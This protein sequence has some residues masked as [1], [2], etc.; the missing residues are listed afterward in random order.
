[1]RTI[2]NPDLKAHLTLDGQ[3]RVRH[4]L[5]SQK[6]FLSEMGSARQAAADYLRKRAE[7]FQIP[8]SQLERL[9]LRTTFLDPRE[10]GVEY[11]EYDAKRFFAS[12]TFCYYQTV[13]NTPVWGAGTTVTVKENPFRITHAAH[14]GRDGLEVKLPDADTIKRVRAA[15]IQINTRSA[16]L[17][18]NLT[19]GEAVA[20][21]AAVPLKAV[22]EAR[23]DGPARRA[24]EN[25]PDWGREAMATRGLFWVYRYKADDRVPRG[26]V[27]VLAAPRRGPDGEAREV[28]RT[29]PLPPVP[30]GVRD[31]QH[32]LVAE[33]IFHLPAKRTVNWRALVDV[34]TGAILYLRALVSGVNGLVFTDDPQTSTGDLTL[35]PDDCDAVLNPHR[36]N[37][38]LSNLNAPVGGVQSLTGTHVTVVDEDIPAVAVPTAP[39]GTDFGYDSRTNQFAAVNAYY[40]ADNLFEAIEALGF[41][42]DVYF[43]GTAFPVHLDHRA[44]RFTLDGIE[45]DAF[46]DGD[47]QAD[48]IGLVGYCLSDLTDTAHPLGRAVDKWVHWHEIGGH[49]ILWDHVH[50]A[51]FGFAH[52][53][54]DALAAFQN[55]PVSLLRGRPER[56]RYA[57]FAGLDRWFD[58]AVADGWGWGGARDNGAFDY[59]AEQILATTLFRFYR[60]VGGDAADESK[61]WQASRVSTYLVLNAGGK[62]MPGTNPLDAAAFYN[63]LA[64]ADADNWTTEGWA[65]GAYRKVLRWAFEKQGL[66]RPTG[67]PSTAEGAPDAV[68]LYL[69]DGRGGEYPYQPVHWNCPSVWNRAAADGGT[70]PEPAVAGVTSYAYVKVKNRGTSNAAGTVKVYHCLPG[71]GLT[72]PTDFVQAG[73]IAGLPTGS[74]LANNGNEVIV[75]PFSWTP[76]VN[77]H[78]H[79]C[80]LAVVEAAGDSSNVNNLEPGQTIPEWR[81][82]P[83][84]N[85]IG[86]RNV[87][88]VPGGS[89]ALAAALNGAA[90]LAGN[91]FNRPADMEVR[92]DVPRVL[93]AKGWRL[94]F[95]DLPANK[96]RLNAG[97]QKE[98]R[99]HLVK[100]ADFTPD[101]IRNAAERNITVYLYGDG[102]LLGGMTY[103][104]DPEVIGL[105]GRDPG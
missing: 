46:C 41:D 105:A 54:G 4:I 10:Q 18:P 85:N 61:R 34:E 38:V 62:L 15:L 36:D 51:N 31:G 28:E 103:C 24:A 5:Q 96:F 26:A 16:E 23:A 2:Y 90:F 89:T 39:T 76:N 69:D 58:R 59:N 1:V 97:E 9:H 99:L 27:N 95:A 100:G 92:A 91:N 82:V 101:E 67:A 60:S 74:V 25:L 70:T 22:F 17:N 50:T 63:T 47:A 83:H 29:L 64:A 14:Y 45:I 77:A 30:G 68:D 79:D 86:Q 13:H 65:G 19:A 48:G 81:L 104:V 72:W 33:V 35:T 98:L 88:L 44:S 93:A 43:D 40:H 6:Y 55:D 56:F 12:T 94:Q 32:Y 73:P 7:V 37:V 49:G 80:L 87:A 53:A 20:P 42:L 3:D 52:S 75:G 102:M 71:A 66:W 84:D 78:G 8:P 57:P 11:R 21:P